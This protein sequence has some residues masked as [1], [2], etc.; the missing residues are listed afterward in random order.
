[1]SYGIISK[2]KYACDWCSRKEEKEKWMEKIFK[3]IMVEKFKNLIR[4]AR[5]L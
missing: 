3:K 1:M 2:A 4:D 5:I